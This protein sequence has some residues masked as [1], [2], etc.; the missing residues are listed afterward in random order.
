MG[1]F[2]L[3]N[4]GVPWLT[5]NDGAFRIICKTEAEDLNHFVTNCPNFKDQFESVFG[6][7]WTAKFFVRIP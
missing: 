7:T 1:N 4:G 6:L 3:I 2:G 5:D